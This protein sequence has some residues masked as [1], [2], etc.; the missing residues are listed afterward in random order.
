MVLIKEPKTHQRNQS[1]A[2]NILHNQA[3]THYQTKQ[4]RKNT[5]QKSGKRNYTYSYLLDRHKFPREDIQKAN[6]H[7]GILRSKL[8]H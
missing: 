5:S 2:Q 7:H 8:C 3:T 1:K 4:N 6:N